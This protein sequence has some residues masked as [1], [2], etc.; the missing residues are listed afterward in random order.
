MSHFPSAYPRPLSRPRIAQCVGR[1]R[2]APGLRPNPDR[3]PHRA[4]RRPIRAPTQAV[5][6]V[7]AGL[8][9]DLS[10]CPLLWGQAA[11]PYFPL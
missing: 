7:S 5:R 1:T 9:S 4:A 8:P 3:K 10:A 2:P 6:S 11:A